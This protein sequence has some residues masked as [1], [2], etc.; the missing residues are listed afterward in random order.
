MTREKAIKTAK[1]M[2]IAMAV[3]LMAKADCLEEF[4]ERI[5]AIDRA[6]RAEERNSCAEVL[7][8]AGWCGA[9]KLL[10]GAPSGKDKD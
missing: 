10:R 1:E 2:R 8:D 9:A 3:G 5:L 7:A 4:T 6:A